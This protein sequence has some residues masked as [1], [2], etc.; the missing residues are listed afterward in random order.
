LREFKSLIKQKHEHA[1]IAEEVFN[2]IEKDEKEIKKIRPE[3]KKK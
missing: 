2:L 3:T 1:R